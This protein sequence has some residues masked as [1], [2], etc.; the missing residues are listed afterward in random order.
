MSDIFFKES[1]DFLVLPKMPYYEGLDR[2]QVSVAEKYNFDGL[3]HRLRFLTPK[4][5][6]K[7]GDRI[8]AR[9]LART[10]SPYLEEI[11]GFSKH[12]GVGVETLNTGYEW[13]CTAMVRETAS[14][15]P[16]LHRVLDWSLPMGKY[17]HVAKYET[18]HG[19]YYDINWSGNSGIINAVAPKRFVISINQS[20]IPMRSNLGKIGFPIDWF[21]QRRATFQSSGWLPSHLLR[22]VFEIAPDYHSAVKILTETPLAI[23]VIFTVC[24]REEGEK[25]IIERQENSAHIIEYSNVCTAN[26]WQ[27]H[28]WS[29]HPR[30]IRSRDRLEAAKSACSDYVEED[31]NWQWLRPPILNKHSIMAFIANTDGVMKVANFRVVDGVVTPISYFSL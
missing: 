14:K 18:E 15:H 12:L 23:P 24:G 3:V 27:E 10:K 9:L 2:V 22:H 20:P 21:L 30:P 11:N 31:F 13:A 5:I 29:G 19:P 8:G 25:C 6:L 17:M 7:I 28:E 4:F 1:E 16:V 26:H